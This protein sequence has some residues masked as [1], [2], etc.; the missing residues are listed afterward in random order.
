MCAALEIHKRVIRPG[1][2]VG[3]WRKTGRAE[4][5]WAGFA[6]SEILEWWKR[7]GG[8]LVDVPAERFAERSDRTRN[9]I[10]DEMPNAQ[11]VRGLIVIE[12]ETPLLKIVTRP[13]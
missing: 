4:I 10:W 5:P 11:V 7:T 1:K 6:R 8:E 12:N 3:V 13:S 2:L 9:L